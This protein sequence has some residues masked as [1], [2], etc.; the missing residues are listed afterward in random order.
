MAIAVVTVTALSNCIRDVWSFL[1]LGKPPRFCLMSAQGSLTLSTVTEGA[2]AWWRLGSVSPEHQRLHGMG[3]SAF[4]GSWHV[5]P[6]GKGLSLTDQHSTE[7]LYSQ[8][9]EKTFSTNTNDDILEKA[10]D[11]QSERVGFELLLFH[12]LTL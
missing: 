4:R 5:A 1:L 6:G 11:L 10:F 9:L 8:N 12:L 2:R 3:T 7:Y